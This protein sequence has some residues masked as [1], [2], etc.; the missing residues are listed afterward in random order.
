MIDYGSSDFS[1]FIEK[2]KSCAY[3]TYVLGALKNV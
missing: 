2:L 1:W 3:S